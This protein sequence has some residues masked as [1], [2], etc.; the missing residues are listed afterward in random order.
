MNEKNRFIFYFGSD[1]FNIFIL[2]AQPKFR[3]NYSPSSTT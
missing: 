1:H 3:F 2:Q